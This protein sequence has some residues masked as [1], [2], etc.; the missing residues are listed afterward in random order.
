MDKAIFVA[1]LSCDLAIDKRRDSVAD[2]F[3]AVID[4]MSNL[5]LS[6]DL[7]RLL[8]QQRMVAVDRHES[9]RG[10]RNSLAVCFAA[11]FNDEVLME[12]AF[13]EHGQSSPSFDSFSDVPFAAFQA[14]NAS[15]SPSCQFVLIRIV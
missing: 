4:L 2:C 1:F 6:S 13:L 12:E 11:A 8:G 9:V 3:S 10:L 7:V 15:Q 14:M 5:L